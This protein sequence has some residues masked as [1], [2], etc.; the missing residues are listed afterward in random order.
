MKPATVKDW[1]NRVV[2]HGDVDPE[3]LLANPFNWRVHTDNQQKALAGAIDDVGYIRSVTV[4]SVTGH[5]VDGHLRVTL[6]LRSHVKLIP[7][8]YVELTEA[9]EHEALVTLDP[10][11]AMASADKA[12]LDTLLRDVKTG[13][14]AVQQML[15]ELSRKSALG[16]GLEEYKLSDG[17]VPVEANQPA[18]R[19]KF[20]IPIVVDNETLRKWDNAKNTLKVADDSIAFMRML[21]QWLETR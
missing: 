6:A 2:G 3:S 11:A 18:E 16:Y 10:I 21:E 19:S 12:Q 7:V 14:V 5:V 9:E 20:P 8:E 17:D 15:A 13:D 4:N 1:R